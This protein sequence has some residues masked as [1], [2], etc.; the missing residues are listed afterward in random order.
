MATTTKASKTKRAYDGP[1]PAEKMVAQLIQ[2]MEAGRN[3]WRMPWQGGGAHRNILTGHIYSGSNPAILQ[4][5]QAARESPYSLWVGPGMM[6]TRQWY[7]KKGSNSCYIL[8]P[9]PV[10]IEKETESG[11][12]ETSCFMLF[13]PQC[14]FNVHDIHGPGLEEAIEKVLSGCIERPEEERLA[15][16]SS[17]LK[18]WSNKVKTHNGG[19][20]A[21][22]SPVSDEVTMP[23]RRQFKNDAA[24]LATLAHEYVHSTGHHSRLSRPLCGKLENKMAYAREELIAELGAYLI[25]NR[26]EIDSNTENHAAYLSSWANVLKES[27]NVLFKVLSAAKKAADLV[28][29]ELPG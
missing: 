24:Y 1:T 12:T 26:L 29:P 2:L 19:D 18:K 3:P 23:E 7:P 8:A 9:K 17:Q 25:C 11:E 27:P 21:Y 28:A 13:K 16:A 22:Y 14:L 15:G 4:W 10:S 20:R 5:G 6:K